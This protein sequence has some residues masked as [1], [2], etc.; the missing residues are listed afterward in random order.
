MRFVE[1]TGFTREVQS[2]L[3]PD[4]YRK[5]QN[6]LATRATRVDTIPG[7][8]GLQ[9]VRW[10]SL[11]KGKRGGVRVIFY[12]CTDRDVFLLLAIYT[13]SKRDDLTSEQKKTLKGLVTRLVEK[14]CH[15]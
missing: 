8:G 13:K 5:L 6:A 15:G 11:Q 1:M 4:E 12:E 9:K 14:Y 10:G 7:T 3:T 2:L